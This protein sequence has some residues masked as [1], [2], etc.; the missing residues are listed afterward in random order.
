M[1]TTTHPDSDTSILAVIVLYRTRPSESSSVQTLLKAAQV[2]SSES[3][4]L[5]L[6]ILVIDNTP[7]G[8]QI[9]ALPEGIRYRALPDNPGLAKPY[10]AAIDLAE[11]ENFTWLLTLDQDT[12]LPTNFLTSLDRYAKQYQPVDKVA[13]IVP[14][15]VDNGRP[16]SP[17]RFVGGFLPVVLAPGTSGILGPHTSAINSTS[18]LRVSALRQ[19][20]GYDVRFPL[21]HSDTSLYLRLDRA[22]KQVAA[23]GDIFV[24]HELAIMNRQK[25]MSIDRYQHA[26]ADEC[27]FWDLEMGFWGRVERLMRL[28]GRA[29]KDIL[30]NEQKAFAAATLTEI[31]HRL[32]T[33]RLRRISRLK[34]DLL[35]SGIHSKLFP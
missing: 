1:K 21:H 13:A 24:S 4:K 2:A 34:Q 10:N 11:H 22:G 18:L 25:R 28:A 20:G 29:A 15:V 26:L 14:M 35:S 16:I 3:P 30:H 12:S 19:L 32:L 7:G 9:E 33:R 27:A 23:A 5:R 8:Q 31:R 6:S 17:F